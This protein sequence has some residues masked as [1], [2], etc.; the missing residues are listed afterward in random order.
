[1][2]VTG[3]SSQTEDVVINW[4]SR[5]IW[6]LQTDPY[7]SSI[8]VDKK[9]CF[10]VLVVYQAVDSIK[11]GKLAT[12]MKD[13]HGLLS[14]TFGPGLK[15]GVPFQTFRCFPTLGKFEN[16]HFFISSYRVV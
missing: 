9:L 11:Y 8:R 15:T 12:G 7:S 10:K 14:E 3:R 2:F 4:T 16:R 1:M 6:D 13:E 5:R